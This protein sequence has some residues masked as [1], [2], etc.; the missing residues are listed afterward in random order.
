M[1]QK[2]RT[3]VEGKS[4]I[5]ALSAN[6]SLLPATCPRLLRGSRQR[7]GIGGV[8]PSSCGFE[9]ECCTT[10]VVYPLHFRLQRNFFTRAIYRPP[11]WGWPG[12]STVAH[13]PTHGRKRGESQQGTQNDCLAALID[14]AFFR[15]LRSRIG[16]GGTPTFESRSDTVIIHATK[17]FCSVRGCIEQ[18]HLRPW[19]VGGSHGPAGTE[20]GNM[21]PG[22]HS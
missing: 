15:R 13:R 18:Q 5:I 2:P 21:H 6:S 14:E 17:I 20:E 10:V 22:T 12:V 9:N 11:W 4:S 19:A 7:L 1:G 3:I 8:L 16:L